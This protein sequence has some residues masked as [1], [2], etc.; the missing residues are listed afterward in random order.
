MTV[1]PNPKRIRRGNDNQED[2]D[3]RGKRNN[4]CLRPEFKHRDGRGNL[5]GDT[6]HPLLAI[7]S[8]TDIISI[9]AELPTENQKLIPTANPKAGST[10]SMHCLINPPWTGLKVVISPIEVYCKYTTNLITD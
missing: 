7:V 4:L 10:Y 9:S 2:G 6:K 3:I 5:G 1:D 8:R